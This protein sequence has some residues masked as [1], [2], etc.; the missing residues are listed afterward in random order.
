MLF[1]VN[2]NLYYKLIT[3]EDAFVNYI[4]EAVHNAKNYC[5]CWDY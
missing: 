4:Q 1:C 5:Y 3:Q 2:I